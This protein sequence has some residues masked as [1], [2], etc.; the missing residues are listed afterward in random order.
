M[1]NEKLYWSKR[2]Y[3]FKSEKYGWLLY[4]GL[5]NSFFKLDES[6]K[7][8]VDKYISE[9]EVLSD[10]I[11]AKFKKTGVLS[12]YTDEEFDRM[13]LLNW[14]KNLYGNERIRFTIAP[15]L[16]CN[17]RCSYCYEK[18][19]RNNFVMENS[20]AD[21]IL[22]FA[23]QKRKTKIDL[24]WYGGEPL[25]AINFIKYFNQKSK[26]ENIELFQSIVTNGYLLSEE[27]VKYFH[28]INLSVIQITLDGDKISHNKRRPHLSNPDSFTRIIENLDILHAYCKQ[29]DYLLN[30]SIRVNVDKSNEEDYPKIRKFLYER[31][32]D[33]FRVYYGIVY[34]SNGCLDKSDISFDTD[35]EKNYLR[36]LNK[37]Y[38]LKDENIYPDSKGCVFCAAQTIDNYVLDPNGFLYKCWDDV[39]YSKRVIG[40]L[41]DKKVSNPLVESDYLIKSMAIFD[42]QCKDCFLLYSCLGGCPY[43]CLYTKKQCLVLKDNAD[44]F[45]EQ[46]YENRLNKDFIF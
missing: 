42:V 16:N 34:N 31:Y 44:Y 37:K 14:I 19:A 32:G 8:L 18:N 27:I 21:K 5:S 20:A 41:F 1:K 17:F 23:K 2:N 3:I 30:V 35:D 4:A 6:L 7:S 29:N 38:G 45:L 15:T 22:E 11:L 40:S 28:S 39:G 43:K 12:K 10:E 25:L 33:F 26:E 46:Y 13:Y 24:C 9:K 36:K